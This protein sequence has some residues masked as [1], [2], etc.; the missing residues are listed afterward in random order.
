MRP[1]T[2]LRWPTG[3][4]PIHLASCL[5]DVAAAEDALGDAFVAALDTWPRDGLPDQPEAWLLTVARNKLVTHER[6]QR[7]SKAAHERALELITERAERAVSGATFPDERLQLMFV[8]AHPAIDPSVRTPLVLQ[9]V[10]G[11][12]AAAIARAFLVAPR[13]MGQRLVRAK[14]KI[15]QAGIAFQLP[16]EHELPER[17]EAVLE[18][19]YAVY[20]SGWED[21]AGADPQSRGLADEALWLAR[22]VTELLPHEPEAR[23]LLALLLHCEARRPARRTVDGRYVPLSEQDPALWCPAMLAEAEEQ[24][25]RAHRQGRVGRFQLEAAIQSVHAERGRSGR[26][27][28]SAVAMFYEELVARA[29]TLGALVGR[30]AA[31]AEAHGAA[32]GLAQLE[33]IE[34]AAVVA[35]QPFWAVRAHLLVRTGRAREAQAAFGRAIGLA[36]DPALRRFLIERR[37]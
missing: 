33:E 36:E 14:Q 23:G 22:C 31:V 13:A 37:G 20:G 5:R 35:Y 28:W 9:T 11:M 19:I 7:S 30:A 8:S 17:L 21:A 29:P 32:R 12:D 3:P 1:G 4:A 25:A 18:A 6:H 26:T 24:L 2:I 16:E 34:P 10:L 15:R 27:E